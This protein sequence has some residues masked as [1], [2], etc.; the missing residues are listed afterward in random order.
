M[1]AAVT[2]MSHRRK[3]PYIKFQALL[4]PIMAMPDST[5][6]YEEF[7]FGPWLTADAMR[8]YVQRQFSHAALSDIEALPGNAAIVDLAGLPPALIV[9]VENDVLRDEGESYAR[10]LVQA[11]VAVISV[12]YLGCIHDFLTLNSL[13]HTATA[14]AAM[15]QLCAALSSHLGRSEPSS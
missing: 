8:Y 6:S 7:A 11:G 9:T 15:V 4:Y 3:G 13:S 12:R 1:A 2:I 14:R 10:K 5:Q